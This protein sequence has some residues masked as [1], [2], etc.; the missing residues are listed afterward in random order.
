MRYPLYHTET[1]RELVVS[2]EISHHI[3]PRD[4]YAELDGIYS[5]NIRAKK[6]I[7]IEKYIHKPFGV[8]K[9]PLIFQ[10]YTV[11]TCRSAQSQV[12]N[13]PPL[14]VFD[15]QPHLLVALELIAR[16]VRVKLKIFSIIFN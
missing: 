13:L 2:S 9:A 11:K 6:K 16:F 8:P 5:L 14:Q 10:I 12:I 15:F 7:Q 3:L 4:V 1:S